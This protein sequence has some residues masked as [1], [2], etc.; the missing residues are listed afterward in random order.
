MGIDQING[1]VDGVIVAPFAGNSGGTGYP[2][3]YGQPGVLVVQGGLQGGAIG[4]SGNLGGPYSGTS[5]GQA[6]T[7]ASFIGTGG[8]Y[9]AASPTLTNSQF[10]PLQLDSSGNLK[11]NVTNA[12]LPIYSPAPNTTPPA[13]NA[14]LSYPMGV[15]S[16]AAPVTTNGL[17][18]PLGID[19][20]SNLHVTGPQVTTT[21]GS[22]NAT[23]QTVSW[24]NPGGYDG[25]EVEILGTWTGTLSLQGITPAGQTVNLYNVPGASR[26]TSVENSTIVNRS[27]YLNVQ[28][29]ST[30]NVVSS[31]TWTGTSTITLTP[32]VNA[33]IASSNYRGGLNEVTICSN[34]ITGGF[35]CPT[36]ETLAGETLPNSAVGLNM[37]AV[38]YAWNGTNSQAMTS[39]NTT[40]QTDVT[41]AS[42]VQLLAI[43]GSTSYY[44]CNYV[45]ET[46]TAGATWQIES[47]TAASC[48]TPTATTPIF[49]GGVDQ[50]FPSPPVTTQGWLFRTAAASALCIVVGGSSPDVRVFMSYTN[51]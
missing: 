6:A 32:Q 15:V 47:A 34:V 14:V 31:G 39:C 40:L 24:T 9:N 28:G 37:A 25:L 22:V 38:G 19:Q 43:N 16:S 11:V 12:A 1:T 20:N 29:I 51:Y 30:V 46:T 18:A 23:A 35:T 21:T 4:V 3:A 2:A 42:S 8:I 13:G 5:S 36:G 41:S 45:I 44:V 27:Y 33:P 10:G 17:S 50:V 7:A 26:T 49:V 48:G